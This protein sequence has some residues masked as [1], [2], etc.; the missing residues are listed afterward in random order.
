MKYPTPRATYSYAFLLCC[1]LIGLALYFQ[2][3]FHLELCPLCILQRFIF[4]I[5]A[6][7]FMVGALHT[8]TRKVRRQYSGVILSVASLGLAVA[9]RHVW[10]ER[11]PAIPGAP[12][13]GADIMY[14]FNTLP[15]KDFFRV[16]LSGTGECTQE[17]WQ[18]L[19]LTLPEWAMVYYG[20]FALIALWQIYRK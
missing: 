16:L 14:M 2:A 4:L 17:T 19:H 6:L 1:A 18:F 9:G 8:Q 3:V 10:L 7:L 15:F 12:S 13:C 11:V 5:L 20:F